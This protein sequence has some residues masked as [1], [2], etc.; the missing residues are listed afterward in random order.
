MT[1]QAQLADGR[2]LEFPDGTD[3]S[4]VQ[5]TVKRVIESSPAPGQA[6][7]EEGIGAAFK[8]GAKRMGSEFETALES[9]IN[10]ELAAQRGL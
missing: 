7:P 8:G 4:V 5:A 2:I 10:P 3:P 6:A 9:L 1:I